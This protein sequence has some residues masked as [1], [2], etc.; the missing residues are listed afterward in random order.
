MKF[1]R[2]FSEAHRN[3][4]LKKSQKCIRT[5]DGLSGFHYLIDERKLSK[6]VIKNFGLGYIPAHVS[7]Q[8][9]GRVIFPLYDPSGNLIAL[10]SRNVDGGDYLPVYW[11][12]HYKKSFYLYGLNNAKEAMRKWKFVIVVEGQIDA[13]QLNNHGVENV[14]GLGCTQLSGVQL[15]MIHR[16]CDQII[17]LLDSD[18]GKGAGQV[19]TSKILGSIHASHQPHRDCFGETESRFNLKYKNLKYKIASVSLPLGKDPDSYVLECGI[20]SLKKLVRKELSKI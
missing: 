4:L 20:N 18:T 8:L 9:A 10:T 11:H 19:G 17:L 15:S 1:R 14:I 6:D 5:K 7:H 16:Y 12:E 2:R 13:L 3:E